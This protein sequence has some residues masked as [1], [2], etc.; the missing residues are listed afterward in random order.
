MLPYYS[1][2]DFDRV[3]AG[4]RCAG[5]AS[6]RTGSRDK[7]HLPPQ[8]QVPHFLEK[9]K[10][11]STTIPNLKIYLFVLKTNRH[12]IG[13]WRDEVDPAHPVY[14][15]PIWLEAYPA[16]LQTLPYFTRAAGPLQ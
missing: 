2:F 14:T 10:L 9:E 4:R 1:Y 7:G 3:S 13:M 6:R 15:G 16:P 5:G 8:R 11:C 12:D